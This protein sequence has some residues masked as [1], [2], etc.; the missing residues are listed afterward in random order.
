MAEF[1]AAV[2]DDS[3]S[4]AAWAKLAHAYA[5]CINYRGRCAVAA[6]T[7]RARARVAA[8]RALALDSTLAYAWL[9]HAVIEDDNP[10]AVASLRRAERLDPRDAD[11][12][13]QLGVSL[14]FMGVDDESVRALRRAVALDPGRAISYLALGNVAYL[15]QGNY[16]DAIALY[17]TAMT[18]L[19]DMDLRDSQW[20]CI[21]ALGDTSAIRGAWT[22]LAAGRNKAVTDNWHRWVEDG[23]VTLVAGDTARSNRAAD[24]LLASASRDEFIA[25]FLVRLGRRREASA[26]ISAILASERRPWWTL[27]S[28]ALAELDALPEFRSYIEKARRE[29]T[30]SPK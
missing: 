16:G 25:V 2:R 29:A 9:A 30:T 6:D 20:Q 21:L 10:R 17:D 1:R 15:A 23:F 8:N 7:I 14:F 12:L 5:L 22:R 11:V 27:R 4:A 3:M 19:P 24:S 13:H 26:L 18:L 28:P